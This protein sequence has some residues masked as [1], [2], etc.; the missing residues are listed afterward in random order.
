MGKNTDLSCSFVCSSIIKGTLDWYI[1][2]HVGARA[3]PKS[4]SLSLGQAPNEANRPKPV[5]LYLDMAPLGHFFFH[6]RADH[7]NGAKRDFNQ[8]CRKWPRHGTT[9]TTVT[10]VKKKYA[11]LKKMAAE[12]RVGELYSKKDICRGS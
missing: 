11:R 4:I 9:V 7:R 5:S 2:E 1:E 3:C 12:A 10:T 8:N 6:R